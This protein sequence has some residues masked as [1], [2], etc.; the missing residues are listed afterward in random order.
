[1]ETATDVCLMSV[2]GYWT[3]RI[4]EQM[5]WNWMPTHLRGGPPRVPRPFLK[6]SG[7][8]VTFHCCLVGTHIYFDSNTFANTMGSET[9]IDNKHTNDNAFLIFPTFFLDLYH[10]GQNLVE[11][12]LLVHESCFNHLGSVAFSKPGRPR[13]LGRVFLGRWFRGDV[14][15]ASENLKGIRIIEPI[16]SSQKLYRYCF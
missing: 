13:V 4:F 9:R 3:Q 8:K 5:L 12:R 1:M 14:P 6:K 15:G 7:H 2:D 16:I 11:F 10:P